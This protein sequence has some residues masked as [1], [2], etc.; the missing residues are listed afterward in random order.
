MSEYKKNVKKTAGYSKPVMTQEE[1]DLMMNRLML[2]FVLAV[3][4][5]TLVMTLKNKFNTIQLYETVGPVMSVL[6]VV[7]FA[8]AAVFFG[9]RTKRAVND[10][11]KIL[12]RWNV[13]FSGAISLFCGIIFF[14]NP[15]VA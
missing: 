8:L 2:G 14:L 12:T 15:S 5:V 3:C 4:A 7:L 9:I 6:C 11:K 13:L 1:N 10:S